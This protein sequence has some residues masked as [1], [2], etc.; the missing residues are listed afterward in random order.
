MLIQQNVL[1]FKQIYAT[2]TKVY[3][4]GEVSNFVTVKE[5]QV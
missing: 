5:I 1:I 3:T 2:S 4:S